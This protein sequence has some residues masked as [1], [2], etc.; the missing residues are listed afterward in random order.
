MN[1]HETPAEPCYMCDTVDPGVLVP[2]RIGDKQTEA[3]LWCMALHVE[4]HDRGIC[5]CCRPDVPVAKLRDMLRE[6][7]LGQ[8]SEQVKRRITRRRA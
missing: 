8:M 3:H 7:V 2:V 1:L 4:G 5:P 6:E